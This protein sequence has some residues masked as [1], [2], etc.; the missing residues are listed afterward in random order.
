MKKF[1]CVPATCGPINLF[2][3]DDKEAEKTMTSYRTWMNW[4]KFIEDL[5]L[6]IKEKQIKTIVFPNNEFSAG[7]AKEIDFVGVELL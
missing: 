6:L 5:P 1:F 4:D 7:L 2:L 3:F